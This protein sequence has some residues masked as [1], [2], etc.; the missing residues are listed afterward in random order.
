MSRTTADK[1]RPVRPSWSTAAPSRASSSTAMTSP[2][3]SSRR[4]SRSN[5][6]GR[7][8][9][10]QDEEF[11]EDDS[12]QEDEEADFS[13]WS[14]P[15]SA[16]R[17]RKRPRLHEASSESE[18]SGS[19]RIPWQ[20]SSLPI[21]SGDGAETA[22]SMTASGQPSRLR[23]VK[24]PEYYREPT[25]FAVIGEAIEE[26]DEMRMS[27]LVASHTALQFDQDNPDI[28]EIDSNGDHS[29]DRSGSDRESDGNSKS[30]RARTGSGVPDTHYLPESAKDVTSTR[31][32]HSSPI[33]YP[34][35]ATHPKVSTTSRS[36]RDS[37]EHPLP[38]SLKDSL[39]SSSSRKD[40][41]RPAPIDQASFGPSLGNDTADS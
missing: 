7:G 24:R 20:R 14:S 26:E 40:F 23:S 1:R 34:I 21:L 36:A 30:S 33:D 31:R 38:H 18:S 17:R 32:R 2:P 15:S 19:E 8:A 5:M 11:I 12:E 29:S 22:Q 3:S 28:D 4:I 27:A 41:Q 39:G 13:P 9:R 35:L 37:V 25:A 6:Q 10:Q 16:N